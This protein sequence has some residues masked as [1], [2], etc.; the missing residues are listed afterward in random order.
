MNKTPT[1]DEVI[2]MRADADQAERNFNK[3]GRIVSGVEYKIRDIEGEL[4]WAKR[5]KKTERVNELVA[6]RD[7]AKE[8]LDK[9]VKIWNDQLDKHGELWV[10]YCKALETFRV[11]EEKAEKAKA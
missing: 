10:A 1:Y 8:S 6:M 9:C 2:A 3:I 4:V 5:N 7:E 11:E